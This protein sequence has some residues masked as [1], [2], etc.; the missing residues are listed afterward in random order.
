MTNEILLKPMTAEMYHEFF[1][2]YQND[3][4]LYL[5]KDEFFEY[6]YDES[7]VDVYIQRQIDLKRLPFAIMLGNEIVGE[8]KIHDIVDGES[9]TLGM[10]MKNKNHKDRGFGS[11]AVRL[12]IEYAFY[13][14]DI[15]VLY[16]DSVLSNT[17]SQH[18]LE[19]A[20]FEFIYADEQKKYYKITRR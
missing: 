2:E 6:V 19:K 11:R 12:A 17:R 20:G 5:N 14:L 8:L 13:E 18:V 7:K 16:A 4:D 3:S 10:T 1:R 15:P 9:A